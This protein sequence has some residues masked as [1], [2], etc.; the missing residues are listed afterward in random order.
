M[1]PFSILLGAGASYAYG[2]PMM[3]EFYCDFLTLINERYSACAQLAET[4]AT[5]RG[6]EKQDLETLMTDLQMV[7]GIAPGLS[8]LGLED[9]KVAEHVKRA[10]ELRGYLDAYIIDTCER[11]DRSRSSVETA[12]LLSLRE[13]GPLWVFTT[14]YDRVLENA[15]IV[16]RVDYSDGFSQAE[17][18]PVADWSGTFTQG[19]RIVKLHGSVNWY[20][21]EKGG[22]IHRLDRGYALPA[23]DF[24]LTRRDHNLR[25]LMIIPTL[26]KQTTTEPYVHLATWFGDALRD[27]RVL[28][29]IGSSLRDDHIRGV[30]RTRMELLHVVLVN[31]DAGSQHEL[32]GF[33]RRTHLLAASAADFYRLGMGTLRRLS[34]ELTE[35]M[36]DEELRGRLVETLAAIEK[37]IAE[38]AA[39][40]SSANLKELRRALES[41]S[42][43]V[44]RNAVLALGSEKHPAVTARV[45]EV[46][47]RD[48]S[49]EVRAAA[50]SALLQAKG[51]LSI[52]QLAEAAQRD[53]SPMVR[54]EA[55]LALG[56]L[57]P[58]EEAAAALNG[59]ERPNTEAVLHVIIADLLN[60]VQNPTLTS[61]EK[62]HGA[63]TIRT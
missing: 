51:S 15:C 52:I 33:P 31:P 54:L 7:I 18:A 48:G 49:P 59:L 24:R 11:F 10:E 13:F 28:I 3:R 40:T 12:E 44:R 2:V 34:A 25:P 26:E 22:Q 53:S 30:V 58:N 6:G 23:H 50:V 4:L 47:R 63:E 38:E 19:V 43:T 39:W 61:T 29:V 14:N 5:R 27:T 55:T 35:D 41:P 9:S 17:G 57:L 16:A 60:G 1:N 20:I 42:V 37:A 36:T 56:A 8:K 62:P 21:D 45:I 46:L 32:L